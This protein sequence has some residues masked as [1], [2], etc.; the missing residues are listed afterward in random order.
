MNIPVQPLPPREGGIL[1]GEQP[2][3]EGR[4]YDGADKLVEGGYQDYLVDV[5]GEGREVEII[6]PRLD[7]VGQGRYWGNWKWVLHGDDETI[8]RR[9]R[10]GRKRR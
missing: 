1:G 3:G 8:E 7:G 5:K 4:G 10:R 2:S 9:G 6:G